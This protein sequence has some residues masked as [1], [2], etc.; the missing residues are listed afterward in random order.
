MNLIY[1]DK[2]SGLMRII[3][4]LIVL[5]SLSSVVGA[6]SNDKLHLV[7]VTGDEEYRSEES[8]PMLAKILKRELDCEITIC[9][10]LDSLGYI[11]PN[12]KWHIAGLEALKTADLMIVFTRFRELPD[13]E[14]KFILDYAE[15]G[16]PMVGF[17]TATHAFLYK[18]DPERQHL[19]EAW[20]IKVFGQKWITHHGHFSD[21]HGYLTSVDILKEGRKHPVL[22]GVEP[23]KAYSWL[24]HVQ[25]KGYSLSGNSQALLTG[26][27]LRSNYSEN[28]KFPLDNP[29]AWTKTYTGDAGKEARVFFTTLGHPFDFKDE[30][31]RKLAINGI[32]WALGL[33]KKIPKKGTNV[34]FAGE[35][36]P[37][38][39]GFGQ[40]YKKGRKPE[41]I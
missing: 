23:F 1:T 12:N 34:T 21:G 10:A 41:D 9:Y 36:N 37:N 32:Y 16:K 18:D 40:K 3:V 17:R 27:S 4:S 33:E 26:H 28:K 22:R 13:H 11:D 31:M 25:G 8:M 24:Y 7:F 14:A 39:S 30:S 15:S 19:N 35:Y 6:Q 29:V 20:P 5:I 2:M 38:N